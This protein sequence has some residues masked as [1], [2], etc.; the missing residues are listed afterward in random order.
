MSKILDSLELKLRRI[1]E[2]SFDGLFFPSSSQ[3]LSTQLTEIILK[4]VKTSLEE[5]E[6]LPDFIQLRVSPEKYDAWLCTQ[7]VLDKVSQ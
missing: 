5:T 3:S 1:L 7:P 6:V 4:A 2:G